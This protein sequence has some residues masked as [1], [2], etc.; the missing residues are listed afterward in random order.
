MPGWIPKKF[1]GKMGKLSIDNNPRTNADNALCSRADD[2]LL[3]S[4]PHCSLRDQCRRKCH[5][6][7]LV[8][9][10]LPVT[11]LSSVGPEEQC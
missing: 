11:K 9:V 2:T 3:R 1:P 4:R 10:Y 8:L 6:E 5:D 7:L